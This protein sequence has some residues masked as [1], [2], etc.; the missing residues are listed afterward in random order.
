MEAYEHENLISSSVICEGNMDY[1]ILYTVL[2]GAL[3]CKNY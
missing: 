3:V 2:L 1:V